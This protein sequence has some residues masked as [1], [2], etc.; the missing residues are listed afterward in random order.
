MRRAAA[1]ASRRLLH[2]V[3]APHQGAPWLLPAAAAGSASLLQADRACRAAAGA[4]GP[5]LQP[6]TP[7]LLPRQAR[8]LA[9]SP[10]GDSGPL[11]QFRQAPRAM[12]PGGGRGGGATDRWPSV[13]Q[14][15][16]PAVWQRSLRSMAPP[17]C[18]CAAMQ[19]GP[20][21]RGHQRMRAGAVVCP[22][23]GCACCRLEW[24]RC[25]AVAAN[26]M[27]ACLHV[28]GSTAM[29]MCCILAAAFTCILPLH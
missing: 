1:A 22:G 7:A 18:A 13:A 10:P 14:A 25:C 4:P 2:S 24:S 16:V 8:G 27:L 3:A 28:C 5:L 23:G 20:D 26:T 15:A 11:R 6:A 19:A 29:P 12:P 9:T 21:G 17:R